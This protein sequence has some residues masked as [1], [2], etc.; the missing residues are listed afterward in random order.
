VEIPGKKKTGSL[1]GLWSPAVEDEDK[2]VEK[3][4]TKTLE[5]KRTNKLWLPVV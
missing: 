1:R 5:K 2:S 4:V 3:S